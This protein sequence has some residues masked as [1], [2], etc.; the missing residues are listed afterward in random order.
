MFNK[1]NAAIGL[2]VML[3]AVAIYKRFFSFENRH[4]F[5]LEFGH[6]MLD[7]NFV[8][9]SFF[10][11][12]CLAFPLNFKVGGQM[13]RYASGYYVEHKKRRKYMESL[14][15]APVTT[16]ALQDPKLTSKYLGLPFWLAQ[17]LSNFSKKTAYI[18]FGTMILIL[19]LWKMK[20]S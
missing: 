3:T 14:W 11:A 18:F 15:R 9:F 8:A 10:S 4:E 1:N 7:P 13:Y 5:Q 12:I 6:D 17:Y 20:K 2:A 19:V 16:I